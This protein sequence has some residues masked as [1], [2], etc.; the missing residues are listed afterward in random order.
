MWTIV[1]FIGAILLVVGG[2]KRQTDWGTPVALL[3]VVAVAVS[4]VVAGPD[5]LE[6]FLRGF[7]DAYN[8][9]MSTDTTGR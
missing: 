4:L 8:P 9:D 2:Y 6:S 7:S 1:L 5:M 3:G